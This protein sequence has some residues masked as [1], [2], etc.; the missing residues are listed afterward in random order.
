[1][2][3]LSWL[4]ARLLDLAIA[5][6]IATLMILT[7]WAV[8]Q[9][10]GLNRPLQFV[11]EVS[12]LLLIWMVMLGAIAAERDNRHL[13]I[14]FIA[15]AMPRLLQNLVRVLIGLASIGLA[16]YMAKLGWDLTQSVQRRATNILGISFYWIYIALPVGFVG[17]AIFMALTL[18]RDLRALFDRGDE[19]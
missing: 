13:S 5:L 9:R 2:K 19:A 6:P 14:S 18:L 4:F 17:M 16:L 3:T 7:N 8:F 1:M 15:D 10:Y 11:E 12:G